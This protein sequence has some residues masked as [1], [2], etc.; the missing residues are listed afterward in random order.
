[1]NIKQVVGL[2]VVDLLRKPRKSFWFISLW[3]ELIGIQ[4]ILNLTVKF[5][6]S[7]IFIG[8]IFLE[9]IIKIRLLIN[10]QT[11]HWQMNQ[12]QEEE[13]RLPNCVW[14]WA[15]CPTHLFPRNYILAIRIGIMEIHLPN[16]VWG[17]AGYPTH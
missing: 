17:W 7:G 16:C 14:G 12:P 5:F 8:I 10:V 15:G 4:R 3:I 9:K 13:I 1:M 6:F 2:I 11:V